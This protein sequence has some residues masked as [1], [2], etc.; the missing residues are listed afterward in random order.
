MVPRSSYTFGAFVPSA[1][2]SIAC[3]LACM[4][5]GLDGLVAC[6][7]ACLLARLIA[8]VRAHAYGIATT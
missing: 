6:F 1:S 8:L 4:H 2:Y 7:L 5:V 3:S